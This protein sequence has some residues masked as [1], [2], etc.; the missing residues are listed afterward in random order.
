MERAAE[1]EELLCRGGYAEAIARTAQEGGF[2][3]NAYKGEALRQETDGRIL[4]GI[5]INAAQNWPLADLAAYIRRY[6][7]KTEGDGGRDFRYA[8]ALRQA[9]PPFRERYDFIAG[10]AA[11]S[12]EISAAHQ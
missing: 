12:G 9:L 1:A 11:V 10:D 6:F 5:S 8:G 2:C 3:H 7:K 4:W